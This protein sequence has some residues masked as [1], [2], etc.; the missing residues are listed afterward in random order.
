MLVF[1]V[2]WGGW[3]GGECRRGLE[4]AKRKWGEVCVAWGSLDPLCRWHIHVSVYWSTLICRHLKCTQCSEWLHL[5]DICFLLTSLLQISQIQTCVCVCLGP[6]FGALGR[7]AQKTVETCPHC[8]GQEGWVQF[9]LHWAV[10]VQPHV[11]CAVW[12]N[13]QP[14]N[15]PSITSVSSGKSLFFTRRLRCNKYNLM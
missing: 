3:C 11:A 2:R 8:W 9:L 5:T 1:G 10:T 12:T 13:I 4:L 15:L 14:L 6:G 7:P